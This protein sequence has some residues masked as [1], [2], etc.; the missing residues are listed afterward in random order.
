MVRPPVWWCQKVAGNIL[1]VLVVGSSEVL[2]LV[3]RPAVW[4]CQQVAR[5]IQDVLVVGSSEVLVLVVRPPVWWCQKVPG[6][7]QD[8]LVVGSSEVLELVAQALAFDAVLGGQSILKKG[9]HFNL[10]C[11]LICFLEL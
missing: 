8:V 9:V 7:I 10:L 3:I 1:D 6:N 11:V 4:W 2:V 5:N